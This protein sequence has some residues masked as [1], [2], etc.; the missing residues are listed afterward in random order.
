MKRLALAALL[1]LPSS[2]WAQDYDSRWIGE[3]IR[4][5]LHDHDRPRVYRTP[6]E[7]YR[8]PEPR[9][10][11]HHRE[12][13]PE[14]HPST[15]VLGFMTHGKQRVQVDV[16]SS[17]V[18]MPPV[19]AISTEANTV[20]GAWRDAQRVWE[21]N[22]RFLYGERLMSVQHAVAVNKQCTRSSGNQS[23]VGRAVESMATALNQDGYKHRCLIIAQPCMP[24]MEQGPAIKSD[25]K[26]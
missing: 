26:E 1:A 7:H 16:L 13:E 2:A 10:E 20:D 3:T 23:L 12:R 8:A 9:R 25:G 17:V 19:H 4:R 22:V 6:R 21:N 24:P 14:T 5:S 15:K 11:H 18:C